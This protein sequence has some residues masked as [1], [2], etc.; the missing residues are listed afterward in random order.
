MLEKAINI[1]RKA[2]EWDLTVLASADTTDKESSEISTSKQSYFAFGSGCPS[3]P[4]QQHS[5]I[6]NIIGALHNEYKETNLP[7]AQ[8]WKTRTLKEIVYDN[9]PKYDDDTTSEEEIVFI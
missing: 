9:L 3:S 4:M 7:I 1:S 6:D 5:F 2:I 8:P